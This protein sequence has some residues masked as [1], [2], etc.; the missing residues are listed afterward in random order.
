MRRVLLDEN[1]DF[2]LKRSF[3]PAFEVVTVCEHGWSGKNNGDLLRAAEKEFY[4]FVPAI[5]VFHIS[6][7]CRSSGLL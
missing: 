6:K 4:V 1:V 5:G 7:R 3:D 2:K